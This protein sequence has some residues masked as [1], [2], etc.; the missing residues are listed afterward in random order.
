MQARSELIDEQL[1]EV[2]DSHKLLFLDEATFTLSGELIVDS[3]DQDIYEVKIE[4]EPF[5][6]YFPRVFEVGERI[7]HKYDRHINS[8]GS[9]CLTTIAKEEIIL[10]KNKLTLTSFLDEVVTPFFLNN[11]FYELNGEYRFGEFSHNIEQATLETYQEILDVTDIKLIGRLILDRVQSKLKL[12]PNDSCYC[13][14]K[15]K[16]KRCKD[17]L[18]RYRDFKLISRRVL[19]ENLENLTSL[20]E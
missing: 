2:L 10:K 9:C 13:G 15:E 5:P 4:L 7:P 16:I 12:R 8:D 19:L 11:S 1:K 17:H 18:E 14:S 20:I 3:V 6:D